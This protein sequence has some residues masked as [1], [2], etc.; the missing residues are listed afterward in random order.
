MADSIATR[1]T[2]PFDFAKGSRG[3]KS[4]TRGDQS[5][6]RSGAGNESGRPRPKSSPK[7][8]YA[9]REYAEAGGIYDD[10]ADHRVKPLAAFPSSCFISDIALRPRGVDDDSPKAFERTDAVTVPGASAGL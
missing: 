5:R 4:C 10:Q 3:E 8:D 9:G 6:H 2:Q 1:L 7:G